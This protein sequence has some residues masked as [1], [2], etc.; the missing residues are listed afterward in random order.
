[1]YAD[2]KSRSCAII[3]TRCTAVNDRFESLDHGQLSS[4]VALIPVQSGRDNPFR[5]G[6][7]DLF[8]AR[9][10]GDLVIRVR[11]PTH[12][13][14][15]TAAND[16]ELIGPGLQQEHSAVVRQQ[17][18]CFPRPRQRCLKKISAKCD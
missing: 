14:G 16:N 5:S 6:F 4:L 2:A 18:A 13:Y 7:R 17:R 10:P 3:E 11:V 12:L 8:N 1:V 9:D 15:Q